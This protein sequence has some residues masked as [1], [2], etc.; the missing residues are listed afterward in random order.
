MCLV[1]WGEFE[2]VG[3]CSGLGDVRSKDNSVISYLNHFYLAGEGTKR[4]KAVTDK[5]AAV[6]LARRGGCLVTL[7]VQTVFPAHTW[8]PSSRFGLDLS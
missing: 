2:Q 7:A 1:I 8:E 4:D 6:T 5:A 3:L